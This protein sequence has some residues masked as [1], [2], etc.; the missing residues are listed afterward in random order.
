MKRLILLLTMLVFPLL[1][2]TA[3][4]GY[5]P[6]DP[7]CQTDAG[8][9]ANSAVCHADGSDPIS[10]PNGALKKV[11]L[12]IATIA[13]IAAVIIIIVAGLEFVTSAGDPKKAAG[14]RSA[15]IGSAVGLV[16]IMAAEG[17]LLFVISKL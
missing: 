2:A 12:I 3:F 11:S 7:A 14:A 10:G 17:I 9:A 13:G 1:P 6:L 16:I 8:A 4:A 5:N 15:I